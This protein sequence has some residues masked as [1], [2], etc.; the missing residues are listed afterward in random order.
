[1]SILAITILVKKRKQ[2]GCR[3]TG[4]TVKPYAHW[5]K[6]WFTLIPLHFEMWYDHELQIWLNFH[7]FWPNTSQWAYKPGRKV[8]TEINFSHRLLQDKDYSYRHLV[9]FRW[10]AD[11]GHSFFGL[12]FLTGRYVHVLHCLW[13]QCSVKASII[14]VLY[15]S[16]I[17]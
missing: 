11:L 4:H 16:R 13:V 9:D 7:S 1:M 15:N 6:M 3:R 12:F 5:L 8:F 17:K 14:K 10:N 2:M